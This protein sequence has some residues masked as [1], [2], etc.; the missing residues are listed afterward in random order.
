MWC[1]IIGRSLLD[2]PVAA[3]V[4][5]LRDVS[6]RRAL[7]EELLRQ[8]THDELSGLP[9]RRGFL[10]ELNEGLEG[11]GAPHLGLLMMDLDGFKAMNDGYGHPAGDR[12]LELVAQRLRDTLRPGDVAGRLGGDEFAV[13]CHRISDPED[14]LA[15]AERI[16]AAISGSYDLDEGPAELGISIGAAL[17]REGDT[18]TALLGLADTGLYAAKEAGKN[19]VHM[20]GR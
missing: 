14:L 2:Q 20:A 13:L 9:N 7:E 10:A 17:A 5:T 18:A 12:L 11:G 1:E 8:A 4:N 16:R 15:V 19:Q 6:D 3:V